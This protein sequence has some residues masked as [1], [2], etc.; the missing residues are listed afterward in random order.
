MK[1]RGYEIGDERRFLPRPDFAADF[2]A[3]G[4]LLP[5]GPKWALIDDVGG[6]AGVT[7]FVRMTGEDCWGAWALLRPLRPREWLAAVGLGRAVL[8]WA[9]A[10]LSNGRAR[11]YAIPA[12]TPAARRLLEVMGFEYEADATMPDGS[13]LKSYRW[14]EV[15]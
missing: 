6:V 1:L 12:D 2:E 7:G 14:R 10:I 13:V 9:D 8:R 4:G 5:D 15:N 3:A 11:I